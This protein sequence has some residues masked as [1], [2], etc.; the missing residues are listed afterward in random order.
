M[1]TLRDILLSV[2]G[3]IRV[4]ELQIPHIMIGGGDGNRTGS[5]GSHHGF[6]VGEEPSCDHWYFDF[7]TKS[8]NNF[9]H[10]TG[11]YFNKVRMNAVLL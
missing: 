6:F 11:K 3:K 9:R 7:R 8:L 5:E 4:V 1:S 10:G 2:R